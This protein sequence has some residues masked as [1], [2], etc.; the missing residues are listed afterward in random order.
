MSSAY[1]ENMSHA[2]APQT[3]KLVVAASL[4]ESAIPKTSHPQ[5]QTCT[6]SEC[7]KQSQ[8]A[9]KAETHANRASEASAG[10]P[11]SRG[12]MLRRVHALHDLQ[13]QCQSTNLTTQRQQVLEALPVVAANDQ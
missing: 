13:K 2:L 9:A 8:T 10:T 5:V 3:R 1:P 4:A 11:T 12:G 6:T 7:T